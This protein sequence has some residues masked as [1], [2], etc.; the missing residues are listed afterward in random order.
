MMQDILAVE[1]VYIHH[2]HPGSA[3][4]PLDPP[5]SF[6]VRRLAG[7]LEL[8]CWVGRSFQVPVDN[9]VRERW[10]VDSRLQ[11]LVLVDSRLA[12]C[13]DSL[14]RHQ[15]ETPDTGSANTMTI[16]H[17]SDYTYMRGFKWKNTCWYGL[18]RKGEQR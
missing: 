1:S 11:V 10:W 17:H 15:A 13:W 6:Q 4:R 14:D 3:D 2:Q 12:G 16:T 7:S 9:L 8:R 18:V 5:D